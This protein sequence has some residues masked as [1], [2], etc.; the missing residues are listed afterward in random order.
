M[1][2]QRSDF[3]R[4]ITVAISFTLFGEALIFLIWGIVLFPGGVLWRKA[5]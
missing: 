2:V 5:V 4:P 1:Y 3:A